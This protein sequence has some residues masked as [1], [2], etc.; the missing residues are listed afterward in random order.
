MA[1]RTTAETLDGLI[2]EARRGLAGASFGPS[3][4]EAFLLLGHVLGLG[5]AQIIARGEQR[6][7]PEAAG[8]F[9]ALLARRLRGEPV[10][11]LTGEREFYGR[12]FRVDPRVLI[13]RPETEHLVAAALA[14]PLPPGPRILDVGTGSGCLAVTLAAELPEARV[15]ATDLSPGALAVARGNALRH[16][17]SERVAFVA[18]DLAM[19]LRLDAFDLLLSNPP[20]V[21]LGDAPQLST[22]VRDFEPYL[23]LFAPRQGLA[24]I[25]ALLDAAAGL[26]RGRGLIFEIGDGQADA[27]A[28]L[29]ER[30]PH[31]DLEGLHSDY[32]GKARVVLAKRL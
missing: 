2:A 23:A 1:E 31:L 7:D 14:W 24:V 10:A 21:A 13:P 5:E 22:E 25:E 16:G 27:V 18:S 32:A 17:V 4:R 3:T 8:R 19:A 26:S 30:A 6:V 9:R 20:Y 11:Y 29:L 28:A 12:S 15:T